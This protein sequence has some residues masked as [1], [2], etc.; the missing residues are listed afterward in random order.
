MWDGGSFPGLAGPPPLV[1]PFSFYDTVQ[2]SERLLWAVNQFDGP[3]SGKGWLL[4]PNLALEA[5]V[6]LPLLPKPCSSVSM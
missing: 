4:A 5:S 6:T 1:L 3:L 2:A